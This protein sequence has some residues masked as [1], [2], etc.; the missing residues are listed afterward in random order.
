LRLAKRFVCT[1]F[2]ITDFRS[3]THPGENV[4]IFYGTM[5]VKIKDCHYEKQ[6]LIAYFSI[7]VSETHILFLCWQLNYNF[8]LLTFW[9]GPFSPFYP[10]PWQLICYSFR[11]CPVLDLCV[12][13][14]ISINAGNVREILNTLS[15]PD[16]HWPWIIIKPHVE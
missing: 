5:W 16:T 11:S 8:R 7:V 6:R 4:G 12:L 14:Q 9:L 2:S 10:L 3:T 1:K 13:L 15:A